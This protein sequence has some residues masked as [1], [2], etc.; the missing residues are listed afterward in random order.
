MPA[1]LRRPQDFPAVL[2]WFLPSLLIALGAVSLQILQPEGF[3]GQLEHTLK[4]ALWRRTADATTEAR[5]VI[6]DLDEASIERI[7][8]WPWPRARLA[9]LVETLATDLQV[10]AVGLDMVLP[11]P[12]DPQG[13]ARLQAISSVAPVV[14]GQVFDLLP[15]E[16][17]IVSGAPS[18]GSGPWSPQAIP[19]TGHLANHAGLAQVPCTGQI[20]SVLDS[21]GVLRRLPLVV[22][23]DGQQHLT[24]SLAML[25]C[26]PATRAGVA[27]LVR[28]APGMVWE[29]PYTRQPEA[30]TVVPAA[31]ILLGQ[32]DPALFKGRWVLLGSSAL[33]LN[34]T[35]A[36]PVQASV[37]GVMVH[38]QALS[39]W[40]DR[41]ERPPG[42]WP[43]SWPHQA[44]A[45]GIG[46]SLLS[47]ALLGLAMRRWRAWLLLPMVAACSA[48][49]LGLA[50][51]L[52]LR[53]Q[54]P[55]SVSAPLLAYAAVILLVPLAWWLAQRERRQLV[56]VF[57]SYVAPTVLE[58]ML[59]EGL[60]KPLTP[61]HAHITVLSA[62]MQ[63]YTGLTAGGSLQD[64]AELTRGFLQC[65]TEPVLR[66]QGT[67]DK[68]T[69]D[70]LVAFWGAPLPEPDAPNRAIQAA[71]DMVQAVHRWNAGR[72][73]RGLP[74]ARVRIGIESGNALVGDL[75]TRFRSTYTAV[76]NCI[77]RASKI[78]SAARQQP[79]D[80][81]VGEAAAQAITV[82]PMRKV[83]DLPWNSPRPPTAL[84]TPEGGPDSLPQASGTAANYP[85]N[86]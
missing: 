10:R 74:A 15:R 41:L 72:L 35:V 18:A 79:H 83:M 43:Q 80:I 65:I 29:V 77:N 13:D 85:V 22:A 58:T 7:G 32:A 37:P 12:A 70:G 78:Q 45:A 2:R 34:D 40:L 6:V 28:S 75:G 68:Y 42:Q 76:G 57:S 16:K 59:R 60:E 62:D 27:T 82:V 46:W 14:W 24:L 9:D 56:R 33:G 55:F 30:F 19:A 23:W 69:G 86:A 5:I 53:W 50:A 51:P 48:L 21:D 84:Y 64:S 67:L 3:L 17:P 63:D 39:A 66:H 36:V 38:A 1:H 47:L 71:I 11:A 49:W 8:P 81:L 52:I 20:S 61:R 44:Q 73:A 31:S 54:Q 26:D 4:D 25:Q